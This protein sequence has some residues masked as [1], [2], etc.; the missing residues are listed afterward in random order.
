MTDVNLNAPG[1][2]KRI[3]REILDDI[4]AYAQAT[5]DDGHRNHLGASVIG[6]DC[7]RKLWSTFRWLKHE[8]H[9][10]RM[11]RLFQRGHLEEPRFIEY[12]RGIGFQV[13]EVAE[14]GSQHR[15]KACSGHFGGSLDGINKP[16]VK[17]GLNEPLL[18]E[19]KTSGTGKG[20]EYLLEHGVKLGKPQHYDQMCIYGKH[21]GFRNAL[22]M[23][24]NKNDDTLHIEIVS[25]DW[26]RAVELEK[27][28]EQIIFTPYAPAKISTSP[29]YIKCKSCHFKPIC[30]EGETPE[31]NCRSCTSAV[32]VADGQWHCARF[33]NVIPQE[34]I[35]KG[36]AQWVTIL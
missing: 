8:V 2:R 9:I 18:C 31:K 11:Q 30:H 24:V 26:N 27:K 12:L 20:F 4:E 10:G 1:E 13:W 14:N 23:C 3:A 16:P 15:I 25:L 35:P 6:E 36:C 7:T 28:A 17:Y 33:N 19:F 22:Y 5:Y 34:F 29:A 21:Y 32:P